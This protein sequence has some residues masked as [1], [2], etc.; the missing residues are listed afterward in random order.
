[1]KR[2]VRITAVTLSITLL[3]LAIGHLILG[4]ARAG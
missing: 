2:I 1:M 4:R 3:A